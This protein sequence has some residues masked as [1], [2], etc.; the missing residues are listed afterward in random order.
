MEMFPFGLVPNQT[1]PYKTM[2]ELPG[3]DIIYRS[4][5]NKNESA[6]I[7]HPENHVRRHILGLFNR[8]Q[9]VIPLQSFLAIGGWIELPD[10]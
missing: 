2:A 3:M 1:T 5:R 8:M 7:G 4:W 9:I 10:A 6:S